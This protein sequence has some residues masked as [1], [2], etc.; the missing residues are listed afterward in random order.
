MD[1]LQNRTGGDGGEDYGYRVGA[2]PL[3]ELRI[4]KPQRQ[5]RQT[6]I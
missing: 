3:G 1:L 2:L 4:T 5:C 6:G